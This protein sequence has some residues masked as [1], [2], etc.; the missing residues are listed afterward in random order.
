MSI[1]NSLEPKQ[2]SV[3]VEGIK[4]LQQELEDLKLRRKQATDELREI[5]SQSSDVAA[6]GDSTTAVSQS[7]ISEI[8]GRIYLLERIIA[9]ADIIE[10]PTTQDQ[11]QIG[12]KVSVE[13]DGEEQ[14]YT[15]VSVVEADPVQGKISNESPFGQ[16]LLGKKVHEQ[17]EIISPARRPRTAAILRIE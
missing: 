8:D 9:M 11:V 4:E 10:K 7:H 5:T 17:F 2:Y 3:T 15:I 16:S 14:S 1:T 12:S 13:L 6:R